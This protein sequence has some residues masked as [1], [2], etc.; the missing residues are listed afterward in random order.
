MTDWKR[1]AQARG[2]NIP[3]EDLERTLAPL[4]ALEQ[5]FRPLTACLRP[6]DE[7]AAVYRPIEGEAE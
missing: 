5:A 3:A 1:I 6:E 2:L 4:I 7:P